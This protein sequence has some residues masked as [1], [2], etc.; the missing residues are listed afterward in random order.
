MDSGKQYVKTRAIKEAVRGQEARVL[1]AL[2]IPWEDGAPHIHCPYPDHDDESPSWR[3]DQGN[4]QAHC[5]CIEKAHSIFD[6]LAKLEGTDFDA[7]KIR[8]AEIIGRNDLVRS[9]G[10]S[11]FD[12]EALLDPP[13]DQRD[14][15]LAIKYLASRLGVNF[16]EVPRPTTPFTAWKALSYYDPTS[17]KGKPQHVGDYPCA[18]FGT[19][20]VHGH[21][22]AQRIYIGENGQGKAKLGG[23]AVKKAAIAN[24]QTTGCSVQWGDPQSA[25]KTILAEGIETAAAVAH[26]FREEVDAGQLAVAAAVSAKG[27]EG[28][29]PWPDTKQVIV[30]ADRDEAPKANG[31]GGGRRGERAARKFGTRLA[32]RT[33]R[34]AAKKHRYNTC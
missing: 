19:T 9:S 15:D 21:R 22:H 16:D 8:V 10:R 27:M 2:S 25:A 4:A 5:T 33:K 13:S 18:V 30:A 20:D 17:G 11:R 29:K 28:F 12:A 3:W 7:A 34:V 14:D 26:V 32:S 23:R 31:K 1:D 6:V 24:D